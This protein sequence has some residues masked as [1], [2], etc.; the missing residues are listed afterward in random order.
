M[1]DM[2]RVCAFI[3][4]RLL[5]FCIVSPFVLPFVMYACVYFP[6]FV[7]AAVLQSLHERL[8]LTVQ[9]F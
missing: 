5:I 4:F 8:G 2:V 9:I 6:L 3:Y 7:P 1:F